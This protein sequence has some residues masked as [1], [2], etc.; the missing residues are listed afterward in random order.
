M[1]DPMTVRRYLADIES[2]EVVK[3]SAVL[4]Y[5]F[6]GI[7]VEGSDVMSKCLRWRYALTREWG[8]RAPLVVIGLNPSTATATEDDPTVR[9]CIGF[10]RRWGM[11]GL[12]MLNIFAYRAT[13]PREL[14]R[15]TDP[16]GVRNND[17]LRVLTAGV[18]HVLCAWGSHGAYRA[19]GGFV[20]ELLADRPLRC[21]GRTKG[22]HPRH[23]LYL[24]SDSQPEAYG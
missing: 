7:T 4:P 15:V 21:F 10:A 14:R 23:P 5:R 12:V 20:A 16:V 8:P 13:D 1:M 3:S 24:R 19:R 9:R 22:G 17:A 11:G 18:P 2:G 6:D